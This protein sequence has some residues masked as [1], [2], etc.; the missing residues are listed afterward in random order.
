MELKTKPEGDKMY[1]MTKP[2]L[3]VKALNTK[4]QNLTP[5]NYTGFYTI[6]GSDQPEPA[7]ET[8]IETAV[9]N[10]QSRR[11]NLPEPRKLKK[12]FKNSS[13]TAT[14]PPFR[15]IPSRLPSLDSAFTSAGFTPAS[16]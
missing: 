11:P 1:K 16:H 10:Q 9:F 15:L 12:M 3:K 5:G 13:E 7:E 8:Q 6:R 4:R 14:F 2:Q